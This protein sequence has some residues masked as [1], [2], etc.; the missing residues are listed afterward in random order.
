M[1]TITCR[2]SKT[3]APA[4]AGHAVVAEAAAPSSRRLDMLK[5]RKKLATSASCQL[6]RLG[7]GCYGVTR[8]SAGRRTRNG[9]HH[10]SRGALNTYPRRGGIQQS[11][12][13]PPIC[14]GV[15]PATSY[16]GVLW[17]THRQRCFLGSRTAR[18]RVLPHTGSPGR[19]SVAGFL[20]QMLSTYTAPTND[21]MVI[22]IVVRGFVGAPSRDTYGMQK[23]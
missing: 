4:R 7:I 15:C 16:I 2:A 8:C 14:L 22:D 17:V 21:T 9:P 12:S 3:N 23:A 19:V 6:A 11:S 20:S 13:H 18:D 1:R 10:P 5:R